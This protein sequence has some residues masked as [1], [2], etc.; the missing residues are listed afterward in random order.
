MMN[1]RRRAVAAQGSNAV[2]PAPLA[3]TELPGWNPPAFEWS[4]GANPAVGAGVAAAHA[5]QDDPDEGERETGV[6]MG[7]VGV[8]GAAG[9]ETIANPLAPPDNV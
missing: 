3:G 4:G 8:P 9:E 2:M 7:G 1:Q 5:V 6:D